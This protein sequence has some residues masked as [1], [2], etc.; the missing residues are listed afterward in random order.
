MARESQTGF[1]CCYCPNIR[2]WTMPVASEGVSENSLPGTKAVRR[3]GQGTS[4]SDRTKSRGVTRPETGDEE[5]AHATWATF[6]S[7]RGEFAG[8]CARL[9]FQQGARQIFAYLHTR[10][11]S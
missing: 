8:T 6:T 10:E 1:L 11:R 3:C 9:H 7:R 5:S 2:G 4:L